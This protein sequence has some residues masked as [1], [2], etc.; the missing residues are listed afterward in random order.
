MGDD[1]KSACWLE[2]DGSAPPTANQTAPDEVGPTKWTYVPSPEVLLEIRG[3]VRYYPVRS[4]LLHRTR[5]WVHAVD[6]ISFSVNA[7]ETFGLVGE[8]GCGKTTTV[9]QVL[10][11]EHP[12]EGQI[13]FEGK[14]VAK[15]RRGD[16]HRYRR[17]VQGVFQDPYSS[18]NPRMRVRDILMEP[19]IA[20]KMHSRGERRERVGELM[21]LVGLN[22]AMANLYPHQFSGGQRQRIAIARALALT[23]RLIVLDEP[24]SALDVSIR[25]QILN[26]LK[27]LQ[28]KLGVSYLLIRSRSPQCGVHEPQGRGDVPRRDRG[29]RPVSNACGGPSASLHAGALCRR[30]AHGPYEATG[31]G[32]CDW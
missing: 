20:H 30:A 22:G 11:V 26:L 8:S 24:V 32:S 14:D 19:M 31:T 27:E 6:G 21:R 12:P 25:A 15:L 28:D 17:A 10:Q 29:D 13:F 4:G 23:P 1:H 3:L 16:L 2:P 9:R 7:G 5:A 18:L